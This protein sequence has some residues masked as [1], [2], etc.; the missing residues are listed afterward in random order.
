[1]HWGLSFFDASFYIGA[2]L[3]MIHVP[4]NFS[5][6]F[7]RQTMKL[8]IKRIYEPKAKED[9]FRVLVDRLWPRGMSKEKAGLDLW[10][11]DIAP[12]PELRK[13]FNHDP[14]KW[15][16]FKKKYEAELQAEPEVVSDFLKKLENRGTVTLLYGAKDKDRNQAAAIM[17]F[18]EKKDLI[19]KKT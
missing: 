17:D 8:R 11:K 3:W 15:Q 16:E 10:Y 14:E 18:L 7:M 5:S 6:Y 12:S 9:G 2:S 1:M 13:W 4:W 19:P